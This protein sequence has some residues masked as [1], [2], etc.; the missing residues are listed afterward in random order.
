MR[1]AP[2]LKQMPLIVI[3]ADQPIGPTIPGLKAAGVIGQEIPDDFGY[4]TDAAHEKSQADQAALIPGSVFMTKTN[5]GHNVHQE[6]PV[7]VA[8]AIIDV[9]NRVRQGVDTADG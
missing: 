9:V 2:A 3:S 4:V 1:A 5:S 7:L 8:D 6:Q